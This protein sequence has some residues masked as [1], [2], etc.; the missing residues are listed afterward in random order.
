MTQK[1]MTKATTEV[2]GRPVAVV[3]DIEGTIA[4]I[5]FVKDVL[6]P[7]AAARFLEAIEAAKDR[8]ELTQIQD[9]LSASPFYKGEPMSSTRDIAAILQGWSSKD[10]KDTTLKQLQGAIWRQGYESGALKAPL[11]SDVLPFFER[12]RVGEIPV[13]SYSSGSIEAQQLFYRYNEQGDVRPFFGGYFDTTLGPKK[14]PQSYRQLAEKI[15]CA[16]EGIVF[17]SDSEAEVSAAREAGLQA[18]RVIREE[19]RDGSSLPEE[20]YITTFADQLT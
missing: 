2:S 14:E 1:A 5:R 12:C 13:Y 16:A 19:D 10:Y 9:A 20:G 8:N 15:D 6:F 18:I 4:S 17:Y 3:V 11:Y 7:F